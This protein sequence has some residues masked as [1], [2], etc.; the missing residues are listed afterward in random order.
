MNC[1]FFIYAIYYAEEVP[2]IPSF[3][4]DFITERI[5]VLNFVKKLSASIEMFILF[6]P[7][8]SIIMVYYI[9]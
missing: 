5:R 6:I 1:G 7:L 9:D 2:S 3:L 8:H 4:S